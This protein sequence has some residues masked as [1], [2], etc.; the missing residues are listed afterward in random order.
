MCRCVCTYLYVCKCVC[1][2]INVCIY[3]GQS[4]P[5]YGFTKSPGILMSFFPIRRLR[6][7]GRRVTK[8]VVGPKLSILCTF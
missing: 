4:D 7:Q 5:L 8:E 6:N 1:K 2:Y 3:E